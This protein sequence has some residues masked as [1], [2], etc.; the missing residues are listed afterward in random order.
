MCTVIAALGTTVVVVPT[1]FRLRNEVEATRMLRR[2]TTVVVGAG[3]AVYATA[4]CHPTLPIPGASCEGLLETVYVTVTPTI[5][6]ASSTRC[7][8]YRFLLL[9]SIFSGQE[10]FLSRKI[11]LFSHDLFEFFVPIYGIKCINCSFFVK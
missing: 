10:D 11:I 2:S 4:S 5:P 3:C 8:D 6:R 1:V 7:R 9:N